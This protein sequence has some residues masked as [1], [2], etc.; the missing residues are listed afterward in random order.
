MED[1]QGNKAAPSETTLVTT[2]SS[3][4]AFI[5]SPADYLFAR[6]FCEHNR[7]EFIMLSRQYIGPKVVTGHQSFHYSGELLIAH[8]ISI[9]S[10]QAIEK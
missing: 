4:P 2:L 1:V 10:F 7:E 8:A 6:M 9:V 5:G 3:S